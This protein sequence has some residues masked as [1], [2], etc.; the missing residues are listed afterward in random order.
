MKISELENAPQWL[1]EAKTEDADVIIVD[2]CVVWFGGTWHGGTWNG[3]I[4]F[5]GI[6]FG[7]TWNGGTWNGGIWCDGIWNG[8]A[9]NGGIWCDGIWN[10]GAW[11]G[12]TWNDGT[13]NGGTSALRSTWSVTGNET[14]CVIGCKTKTWEEWE[15]W[16]ASD[17]TFETPRDTPAFDAIHRHYR[18][19]RAYYNK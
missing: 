11:N 1:L 17:L 16:F 15:E 14:L 18:A 8:G 19:L 5:G 13:W 9:W 12:G 6:W 2:G 10:G 7:G 4:W 3:G